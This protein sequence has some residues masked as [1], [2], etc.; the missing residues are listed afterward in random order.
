MELLQFILTMLILAIAVAAIAKKYYAPMTLVLVSLIVLVGYTIVTGD[1]VMG[2]STSGN[3]FID[4]FEFV[5]SKFVSAFSSNGIVL[6][7][8]FGYATFMNKLNASKLLACLAIK[9]LKKINAPYWAGIPLCVLI[10]AVLRL[11]IS[12]QTGL[13]ALFLVCIYPVLIACGLSKLTAA[14]VIILS[15]TFD[16][17]PGDPPTNLVFSNVVGGDVASFFIKYQLKIYPFAIL[18]AMLLAVIINKRADKKLGEIKD[19]EHIDELDP[20]SLGIP[21]YYAFFPMLPLVFMIVFSEAIMKT[22]T[23]SA[24]AAVIISLLIV[25]VFEV[26]N[27]HNLKEVIKESQEQFLGMG[28]AYG[29][30]FAMISAAQV[31]AGAIKLVG[32][33]TVLTGWLSAINIPGF[34]LIMMVGPCALLVAIALGSSSAASTTFY[35]MLGDLANV[36]GISA[37]SAVLPLVMA[38]GPGR[39]LSPISPACTLVANHVG[40]EPIELVKRNA[41]PLCAYWFVGSLMSVLIM[42]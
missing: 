41:V 18:V 12:A 34:L 42:G 27:K 36:A 2:D 14:S 10:G 7:P 29:M 8:I 31:F 19:A 3:R 28:V 6:L 4:V 32:G 26:I 22:V 11:A 40:V 13:N 21:L 16:W 20:K 35:P 23:I 9:P 25:M 30:M 17:G 39:A 1:S 15:T 38:V 33:F 37:S 24:F 5:C